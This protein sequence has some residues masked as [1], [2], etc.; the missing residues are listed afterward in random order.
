MDPQQQQSKKLTLSELEEKS[1]NFLLDYVFDFNKCFVAGGIFP[2]LYHNMPM[3]D[4]DIYLKEGIN[5]DEVLQEYKNNYTTMMLRNGY[6]KLK[7]NDGSIILDVIDFHK[8]KTTAFCSSFDF[9]HCRA[10]LTRNG[11]SLVFSAPPLVFHCI[12]TMTLMIDQHSLVGSKTIQ[13]LV[14]Y[15]KMGYT[16]EKDDINYLYR[17]IAESIKISIMSRDESSTAD[18]VFEDYDLK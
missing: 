11:S 12:E 8:P 17:R 16:I 2:R 6:A 7:S 3:R 14:K 4:I 13:R 15:L 18:A 9:L 1:T 5:F 10:N